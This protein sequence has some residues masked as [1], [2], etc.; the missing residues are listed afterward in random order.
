HHS[1]SGHFAVR[2]G[3][4]KLLLCR[5]S[6]GW[7]P[8]RESAAA[9]QKM[10]MLQLYDLEDD[11]RETKNLHDKYPDKVA[12]LVNALARA[13]GEGRTTPGPPQ[14]NEGWPNTIP[15]PILK[16]FPQLTARKK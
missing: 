3:K 12:A 11:P 8:P 2:M 10:P 7:S 15:Q 14:T 5:G 13:I 4:W 9:K 6:G 16:K 1:I